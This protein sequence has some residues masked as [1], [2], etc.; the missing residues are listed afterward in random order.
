MRIHFRITLVIASTVLLF[1][2]SGCV[3][4]EVQRLA[5]WQTARNSVET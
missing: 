3:R 4:L 2:S 5:L 1:F